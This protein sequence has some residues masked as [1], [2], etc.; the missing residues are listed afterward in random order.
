MELTLQLLSEEYVD[1]TLAHGEGRNSQDLR[2]G[3]FIHNKYDLSV[4][5]MSVLM[6]GPDGFYAEQASVAY[7][8]IYNKLA[9]QTKINS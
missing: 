7:K 1:W 9:L 2:F 5:P 8:E 6:D 4:I 3:Q